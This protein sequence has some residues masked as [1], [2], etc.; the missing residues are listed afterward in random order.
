MIHT[1]S[2]SGSKICFMRNIVMLPHCIQFASCAS[3]LCFY[4]V[5]NLLHFHASYRF[6][7]VTF[8]SES[9]FSCFQN[10]CRVKESEKIM[11]YRW[12]ACHC[13]RWWAWRALWHRASQCT[14]FCHHFGRKL[15]RHTLPHEFFAKKYFCYT[16]RL[17]P[18]HRNFVPKSLKNIG[19][20]KCLCWTICSYHTTK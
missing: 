18:L 4:I 19:C 11:L 6:L 20:I 9:I 3:H 8:V 13:H 5:F 16:K 15:A 14:K 7:G 1:C 2:S 10:L 17:F 12:W